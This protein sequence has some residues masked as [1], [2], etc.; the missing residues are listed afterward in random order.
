MVR[1]LL[2]SNFLLL[3]ISVLISSCATHSL[4]PPE[5]NNNQNTNQNSNDPDD[6][7]KPD[8]PVART[9][10]YY[11][12]ASD[13]I[14]GSELWKVDEDKGTVT[15][16]K[17]IYEGATGSEPTILTMVDNI[18][19]FYAKDIAHGSEL[20]RSD[21]TE[22]GT[23]MVK[24]INAQFDL[25]S[26][27]PADA[28]IAFLTEKDGKIYFLAQDGLSAT[29]LWVSDGTAEGTK[30]L[31]D[32]IAVNS[33]FKK[34][35]NMAFFTA[36]D[37]V[38]GQELWKTDF[39]TEG[40]VMIKD[41]YPGDN[42]SAPQNYELAGDILY[43]GADDGVNGRELWRS[44]GTE[45]GTYMIKDIE[46]GAFGQT[47][48]MIQFGDT[49]LFNGYTSLNG[50]GLYKTDG[51]AGNAELIKYLYE[52]GKGLELNNLIYFFSRGG[53]EETN[54]L[55]RTDGTTEGTIEAVATANTGD[56]TSIRLLGNKI[57]FVGLNSDELWVSDGTTEGTHLLK[58]I[59]PSDNSNPQITQ[60]LADGRLIFS[61]DDGTHG[62]E[63]WI[64]D[65]TEEGTYMLFDD[66]TNNIE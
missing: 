9:S 60:E 44:D 14:A 3:A 4:L 22:E 18:V 11:I 65:G 62:R 12:A 30:S 45:A 7:N 28:G 26:G 40:T 27:A 58:N 15:L 34:V 53:S 41:I 61:A 21:G 31:K 16:V 35:G 39:T 25:K 59:N 51:K 10:V 49:F 36:N 47:G 50:A 19:Y 24:E 20:W 38:H 64:T 17:D 5:D 43:F 56:P 57:L 48:P 2:S 52:F 33:S 46:P 42:S 66:P 23:Y 63:N 29:K 6:P 8:D 13:G 37:V 32:G 1:K 55:W 54:T